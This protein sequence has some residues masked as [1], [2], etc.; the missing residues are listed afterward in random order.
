MAKHKFQTEVSRLLHLIIHSL[1]SHPEIFLRELISNA[2]D[3][4]DRL[5][6]L[7][8]TDDAFKG[9]AYI[10]KIDIRFDGE[11]NTFLSISDTGIG[12]NAAELEKNLGTIASSGT[13]HFLE[14]LSGDAQKDSSL[15][16]QFGVGFYSA[17]MA[18]ERVEVISRKAGEEGAFL[19]RSEGQGEYEIEPA[20]RKQNG[21]TVTLFLN[22]QGKEFA[23]RWRIEQI[24]KKYSDHIPFPINLHYQE[25]GSAG[26]EESK[27]KEAVEK[28]A[29]INRAAALWKRS[30]SEISD[31]EYA[32]FYKSLSHD[33]EEP[34]QIIHTQAEGA[35]EYTTLFFIPRKAPFDLFFV[36]YAPAVKLYVKRV[37]ITDD[38]KELLPSYLRFVRGVIDSEDLPLNVSREILQQNQILSSIRSAAVKKIL[39][40]LSKIAE[41]TPERYKEFYNE[42]G[43][44]IKEG[45]YQDMAN[46]EALLELVRFKSSSEEGRTGLAAYKERMQTDQKA[47]YYLT[48]GKEDHLRSSPLL[49]AYRRQNIEVLIMDDEIDEIVIPALGSYQG[50]DFRAINRSKAAEDLKTEADKQEESKAAPLIEKIKKVLGEVIKDVRVSS[51]LTEAPCVLVAD[52]DDPSL[53]MQHIF[54]AMGHKDAPPVKPILEIN[55]RHDIILKLESVKDDKL[56][57]D[58]SRLLLEQALLLE[59]GEIESPSRFAQ[60][61][62]RIIAR[63]L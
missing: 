35:L 37:F 41:N 29:Q 32:E 51:R 47:I 38:E 15:I 45:L 40:E 4:L 50:L 53:Q 56:F 46:R 11:K 49:E 43:I 2:S 59:G 1:Y 58:I 25:T 26:E 31:E 33:D 21:T 30:K 9:L 22:E 24:V 20:E 44:P 18:A 61:L 3:A 12:M 62:N 10:P 28:V 6:Y 7:T 48:G 19:W 55:P 39:A 34:F 60:R 42:F 54:K 17:F 8:L 5:K 57:E 13:R 27:P 52:E 36:N 14:S 23:N 63:A 16:G